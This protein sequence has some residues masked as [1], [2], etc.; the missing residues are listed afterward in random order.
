MLILVLL[1]W[2]PRSLTRAFVPWHLSRSPNT[3]AIDPVLPRPAEWNEVHRRSSGQTIYSHR[4]PL[5][6]QRILK[7]SEL[8]ALLETTQQ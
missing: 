5:A 1:F 6:N 4:A 2:L 8:P 7:L 3:S